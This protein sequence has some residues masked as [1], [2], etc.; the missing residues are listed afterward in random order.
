VALWTP[1]TGN[2]IVITSIQIQAFGTTAGTAQVW[3]GASADTTYT[4]GTDYAVFDGEFAPSTTN[5]PGL[6]V[7]GGFWKGQAQ[8]YV[9]RLTTSAALSITVNVWGYEVAT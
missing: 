9:L 5:K 6:F 1:A 3:F 8:D 7:A 4:R 2:N